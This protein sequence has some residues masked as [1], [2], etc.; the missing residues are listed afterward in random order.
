MKFIFR[1][2]C[3]VFLSCSSLFAQDKFGVIGTN[4]YDVRSSLITPLPPVLPGISLSLAH[5][6]SSVFKQV[7]P[8]ST[9]AELYKEL[10]KMRVRFRPFMQNLAPVLSSCRHQVPLTNFSWREES[11]TDLTDFDRTL[12][13]EGLWTEVTIPHFGPPLGRASTYYFRKVDLADT[14][15]SAGNLFICFKGVDYKASVFVNGRYCGSHEGFFAPFEFNITREARIGGNNILIKVENDNPTTTSKD[16]K[17]N[18]VIGDK[19]FAATGPGYNDPNLGWHHGSPGMGIYQACYLEARAPMHLNDIFVRTDPSQEKAEAWIEINN[20]N[21]YPEEVNLKISVYGQN[22]S[23]KVMEDFEYTPYATHIP[24]AGDL[25]KPTDWK[26]EQLKMG[27]G[28]NQLRIP[29]EM[30]NFRF[31]KPE[32][33]WLYQI[34]I[35][36]YDVKGNLA[37]TKVQQFGMRSFSMDT[38]SNPK[39]RMFLNGEMIRLRGAN[40]MG[41][42]QQD[43]IK[44]D[45]AQLEDDILLAKL[46]NMNFLRFTQRPV[47]PEVYDFCDKLGLMFQTDLPLFGTIRRNKFAEAVKQTEEMERLVRSHPAAIMVTYINERFPNGDGYP[48]RGF[49]TLNEY[50][51]LFTALDQ[52]VLLSNPDRV[53]KAGDGDYDPPSP[54]LPDSH[55]Y[56]T[57]YNGHGLGIGEMYKGYWQPIKSGWLFGCGEFGSEGLDPLNVMQKYYPKEWL[58]Q[59]GEVEKSWTANRIS[60]AQTHRFHYMWYNTQ[61]S[62]NDWIDASQDYQSWAT[63]FVTECFRR[64]SRMVSFAIHLFI[65]AWPAGWMKTIMDVDRQPKKAF[66]AYRNA[67]QPLMFSLRSDRHTFFPGEETSIEAWIC[68]D[69]NES[70]Q[71]YQLKYQLEQGKE[72]IFANQITTQIPVNSSQFQGAIHYKTPKVNQRTTYILRASL[73]NEKGESVYQNQFEIEVFP[74]S[75]TIKSKIFVLGSSSGKA[76]DLLKQT[77]LS[78]VATPEEAEAILID[79]FENYKKEEQNINKWVEKGKV[80]LFLELPAQKI[81]VANTSLEIEKT[82]MGDYYFVSPATGHPLVR[83]YR[84]FDFRFWYDEKKGVIAPILAFTVSSQQWKPILSSGATNW[85]EDKGAVMAAGEL[86]YGKGVF[87]ICEVK[88]VDKINC[89]PVAREFFTDLLKTK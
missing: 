80:A 51:R 73:V 6:P 43:V 42:E 28:V 76:A 14:D 78:S 20:Y 23:E 48:Q 34:Q 12:R 46:C 62:L 33:P 1:A 53:I 9:K 59:N 85:I 38:I 71:G 74:K 60:M 89:N 84:Q 16:D 86:K 35:K 25:A 65:D 31:W 49:S 11:T 79:D 58:P 17:G 75:K 5:N 22:F 39:G 83:D 50:Y 29:L 10:E 3:A 15:F 36:L 66:F 88:L 30:K 4:K 24:G 77:G 57:W 47:Q 55:T 21:P 2:L 40:T 8:I 37:D 87:R 56:N 26:K 19:I 68:N 54:G 13:G 45:W 41:F 27:Y 32:T 67:L 70:P 61:H 44:K 82:S 52:A 69:L 64:E 81:S 72:I 7:N 18:P 63:R